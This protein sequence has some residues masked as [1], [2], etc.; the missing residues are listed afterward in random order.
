MTPAPKAT[1]GVYIR[2]RIAV[3]LGLLAFIA[4][5]VMIIAGPSRVKAWFGSDTPGTPVAQGKTGE[6]SKKE[7]DPASIGEC[8]A[9]IIRV[10]AV[11][12]KEAYEPDDRPQLSLQ[13]T[14]TGDVPCDIDLGTHTMGFAIT[15]GEEKYW[16]SRDCQIKEETTLVRMEA[17]QTLDTEPL[18]WD[19]T[20]STPE[21]CEE[22]ERP[23]VPAEGASYHLTVEIAG[24]ESENSKQ[25]ILY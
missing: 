10:N 19:R 24:V 5:L 14:N 15:S 1:R 11:T 22:D 21:T 4:V 13:V 20:R 23:A 18:D 6:P 7:N 3:L 16:D 9:D 25:F 2:R 17:G 12:D 8:D